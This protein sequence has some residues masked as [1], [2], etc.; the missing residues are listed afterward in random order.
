MKAVGR[1][2]AGA[3]GVIVALCGGI[4][5][6]GSLATVR[7][8]S[9]TFGPDLFAL[10]FYAAVAIGGV[11]LVRFAWPG[12]FGRLAR[13]TTA[14]LTKRALLFNPIVHGLLI[15]VAGTIGSA[16]T[17]SASIF[18]V[19]LFA[20][21]YAVASPALIS[22]RPRWWLNA[23]LSIVVGVV[24]VAALTGTGEAVSRQHYGDDAMVMLFPIMVYPWALAASLVVRLVVQ[25]R[26]RAAS[27][28]P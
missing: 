22:L 3:A 2:L 16:M 19:L 8:G 6:L 25:A 9:A 26:R 14:A 17:G 21:F 10:V 15:Y 11:A 27:G 20:T 12:A 24:L 23:I 18:V 4:I 13:R 1:T 7:R 5:F 28:L